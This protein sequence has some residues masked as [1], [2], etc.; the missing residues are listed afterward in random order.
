MSYTGLQKPK[1]I[2]AD[3][4]TLTDTYGEFVVEPFERGFGVTIGNSLR[5]ILLSGLEGAAVTSV[6]IDG[7]LHEFS[8]I[9]GVVEDVTEIILNVKKLLLKLHGDE[10][11]I[12]R[13]EKEGPCRINASDIVC[14]SHVEV[15]NPDNP[16]AEL[17]KDGKLSMEME[18]KK[19]IGYIPAQLNKSEDKEIGVIP[20]DS[21]FSPILKTNFSVEHTRVGQATDFEKLIIQ[22]WTDG[23]INP[24][25]ALAH[26]ARILQDYCSIFVST[27]DE[28][29]VDEQEAPQPMEDVPVFN[30]NLKKTI[31]ELDIPLRAAN[32][33]KNADIRTV[34]ELVQRTEGEIMQIK[35]FGR[36]SL[37]SLKGILADMGLHLGLDIKSLPPE[38]QK[39]IEERNQIVRES[40]Y[41]QSED[42]EDL[43][44]PEVDN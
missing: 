16:I 26:A 34:A 5:R 33:L 28:T 22:I 31:E 18:V 20:I 3:P 13:I 39:M 41:L 27:S 10:P 24:G 14:E 1:K 43:S 9:T 38:A 35:N 29:P 2:E 19:G 25:D 42:E 6:K 40:D 23:S 37:N 21:L 4:N 15:L 12:I 11:R 8:T 32:C 44:E 17:D 30:E 7:A 36:K